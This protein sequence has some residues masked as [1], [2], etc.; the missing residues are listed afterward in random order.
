MLAVRDGDGL[1]VSPPWDRP[2]SEGTTLY[3]VAAERIDAQRM[4]VGR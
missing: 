4:S 1:L 2:V 3:Y